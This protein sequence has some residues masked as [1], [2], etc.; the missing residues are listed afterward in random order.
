MHNETVVENPFSGTAIESCYQCGKCTA[1]CP[2]ADRMDLMP[3]QIFRLVQLGELERAL[4]SQAIWQCVSCLTC[5][6]RCPQS[7]ECVAILDILREMAVEKGF[8]SREQQRTYLFAKA[9]LDNIRRNGRVHEV[10]L[11]GRFKMMGF[12][13]DFSVPL[14][15]KDAM[16]GPKMMW[17]RKLHVLPKR[18]ADRAVVERIFARCMGEV[19]AADSE[20]TTADSEAST[21]A[22]E[23]STAAST[24]GESTES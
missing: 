8:T 19:S 18:A 9:F 13:K 2:M 6:T 16:L 3:N 23:A 15:M 17:R 24:G 7:V 4:K 21:A 11:I 5:A 10:E 20:P 12:A 14:L 1:G 22:S